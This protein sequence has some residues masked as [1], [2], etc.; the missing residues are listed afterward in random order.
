M[1][2]LALPVHVEIGSR[3]ECETLRVVPSRTEPVRREHRQDPGKM[4]K[5]DKTKEVHI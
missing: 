2:T 4:P 3:C 5:R 1:G